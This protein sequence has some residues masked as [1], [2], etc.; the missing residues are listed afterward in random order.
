MSEGTQQATHCHRPHVIW[1][2]VSVKIV[3][4]TVMGCL[5]SLV[6]CSLYCNFLSLLPFFFCRCHV[7]LSSP[8]LQ[9]ALLSGIVSACSSR[10]ER[11]WKKF[12]AVWYNIFSLRGDISYSNAS[13][14]FAVHYYTL[15]TA[16]LYSPVQ[17]WTVL[18]SPVQSWTVLDSP[19]QS[20]I[21][22]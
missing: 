20:W 14:S 22:L 12:V 15:G 17:S 11:K 21:V 3:E 19:V 18:Y 4:K 16:I 2:I 10:M 1:K 5:A 6:N 7:T 9:Y 8:K 13:P